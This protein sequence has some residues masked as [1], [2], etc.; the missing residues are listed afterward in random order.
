MPFHPRISPHPASARQDASLIQKYIKYILFYNFLVLVTS[1]RLNAHRTSLPPNELSP[2]RFPTTLPR[3]P[4]PTS[5][6]FAL[7]IC[8]QHSR[9]FL[10]NLSS[11]SS[12]ILTMFT[13]YDVQ[14]CVPFFVSDATQKTHFNSSYR[15]ANPLMLPYVAPTN[16]VIR[17]NSPSTAS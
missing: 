2:C 11:T 4:S 16:S 17:S 8:L 1:R 9:T 15:S 7:H 5:R 3:I 14:P 12:L 10:Q 13:F 6:G